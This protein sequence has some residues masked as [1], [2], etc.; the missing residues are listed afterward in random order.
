MINLK[1]LRDREERIK[2]LLIQDKKQN[3]LNDDERN[4]LQQELKDCWFEE[5]Y[6]EKL[7]SKVF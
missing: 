5:Y 2:E 3:N 1:T 4:K 6:E 7:K